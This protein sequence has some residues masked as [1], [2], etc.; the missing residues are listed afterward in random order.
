MSWQGSTHNYSGAGC[1][2]S[3]SAWQEEDRWKHACGASRKS[4]KTCA[5]WVAKDDHC[6]GLAVEA[7]CYPAIKAVAAVGSYVS[8]KCVKKPEPGAAY[9][10]MEL[11]GLGDDEEE[12]VFTAPSEV[13]F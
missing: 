7:A 6:A 8:S 1:S 12:T 13:N 11:I 4:T 3:T 10:R 2:S 9:M 5:S